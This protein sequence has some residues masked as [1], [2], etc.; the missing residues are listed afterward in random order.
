M[1]TDTIRAEIRAV[2]TDWHADERRWLE[3]FRN[4]MRHEYGDTVQRVVLFGST[5]RGDWHEDSDIDVLVVVKDAPAAVK[6]SIVKLSARLA[7]VFDLRR[8]P[9]SNPCPARHR[10][11]RTDGS[12]PGA[13]QRGLGVVGRLVRGRRTPGRD[14]APHRVRLLYLRVGC[15]HRRAWHCAGLASPHRAAV[16]N[17]RTGRARR[18]VRR[19]RQ[20]VL[21]RPHREGSPQAARASRSSTRSARRRSPPAASRRPRS[22]ARSCRASPTGA[23]GS[24]SRHQPCQRP[25]LSAAVRSSPPFS[26]RASS[27]KQLANGS[28][29]RASHR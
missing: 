8:H 22:P 4:A 3:E 15:R 21:W 9:C 27:E 5:A 24:I 2:W 26:L 25:L 13:A 29:I 6:N 18:R 28:F 14:A 16:G 17:R 7:A 23:P 19:N 12:R 1:K 11:E 10:L 20:C